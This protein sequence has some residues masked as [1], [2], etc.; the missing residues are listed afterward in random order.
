MTILRIQVPS[1]ARKKQRGIRKQRLHSKV[2]FQQCN[3]QKKGTL[4]GDTSVLF[5][6]A[7]CTSQQQRRSSSLLAR[8]RSNCCVD[9]QVDM[10]AASRL[11]PLDSRYTCE[12]TASQS[13][14]EVS[15]AGA[16]SI[17]VPIKFKSDR[18][19][20]P[21][22]SMM[23]IECS[24]DTDTGHYKKTVNFVDAVKVTEIPHRKAYT[25]EQRHQ[26]WNNSA[27]IRNMAQRNAMEYNW[28]CRNWRQ[29]VEEESFLDYHGSLLH[30]AHHWAVSTGHPIAQ[31]WTS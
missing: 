2:N 10:S 20:S 5:H 6:P 22:S 18:S 31:R 12:K 17:S 13:Q 3:L 16:R 26:M 24:V 25:T 1:E 7:P 28:E 11:S 27:T 23:E 15:I 9:M 4:P 30:P 21:T 14:C 19:S 8:K 29:A